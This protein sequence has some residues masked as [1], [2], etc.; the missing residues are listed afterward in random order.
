MR[1][2]V[3][4][5]PRSGVSARVEYTGR[6]AIRVTYDHGRKEAPPVYLSRA[7]ILHLM[8]VQEGS[9]PLEERS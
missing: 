2:I 4:S 8:G 5:D 7:E 9:R 6:I 3:A 1:Q